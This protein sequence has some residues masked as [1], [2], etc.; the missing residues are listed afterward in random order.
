VR[1]LPNDAMSLPS[2][3]I[4]MMLLTAPVGAPFWMLD[5]VADSDA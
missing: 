2:G 3:S 1:P 5:A 4:V